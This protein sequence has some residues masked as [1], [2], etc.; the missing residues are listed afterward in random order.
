MSGGL[1]VVEM[2][3]K[4]LGKRSWRYCCLVEDNIQMSY[5]EEETEDGKVDRNNYEQIPY[6]LTTVDEVFTWL[7]GRDQGQHIAEANVQEHDPSK[8]Q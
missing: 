2:Y 6:E 4:G 3:N 5:L 8:P 7:K 1:G